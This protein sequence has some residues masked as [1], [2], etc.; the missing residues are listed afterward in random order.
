VKSVSRGRRGKKR[1]AKRRGGVKNFESKG[2]E[3]KKKKK[4]KSERSPFT[5]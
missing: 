3:G 5:L 2:R 1:V 4:K